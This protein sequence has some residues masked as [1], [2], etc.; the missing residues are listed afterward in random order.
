[1]VK[2][3]IIGQIGAAR[4]RAKTVRLSRTF[5]HYI[6]KSIFNI[7]ILTK[8]NGA[9][10]HMAPL[11]FCA[12]LLVINV[13]YKFPCG[14]ANKSGILF[15]LAQNLLKKSAFKHSFRAMPRTPVR[16]PVRHQIPSK[17]NP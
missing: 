8:S 15:Q 4:I 7:P 6:C 10:C 11:I 12:H 13:N 2:N 5:V 3:A 17:E 16:G 9:I 14:N 1:M